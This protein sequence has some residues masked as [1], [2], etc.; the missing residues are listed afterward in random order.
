VLAYVLV[1]LAEMR[2]DN[3]TVQFFRGPPALLFIYLV[4]RHIY[5]QSDNRLKVVFAYLSHLTTYRYGS[6]MHQ[7]ILHTHKARI[8]SIKKEKRV[9]VFE[10]PKILT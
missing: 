9:I 8:S 7:N 1:L 3:I 6:K 4:Q 5:A 2:A 10:E